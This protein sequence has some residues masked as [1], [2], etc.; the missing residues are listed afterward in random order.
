MFFWQSEQF[1]TITAGQN[2][3]TERVDVKT[4]C[5]H[6]L[7]E[8]AMSKERKLCSDLQEPTAAEICAAIRYLEPSVKAADDDAVATVIAVFVW[9]LSVVW[10]A[11]IWFCG[12]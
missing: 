12:S 1:F 8:T 9:V 11:V 4:S 2:L 5:G 7:H 6:G 10:L 3:S